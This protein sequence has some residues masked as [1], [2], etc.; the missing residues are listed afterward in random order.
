MNAVV[1][2][3][4]AGTR[5]RP[6][7]D[8]W[9]KP[10]LPI[11]GRPVVVTLLHDLA[12]AGIERITV[13]TGHLAEQVEELLDGLPSGI[14]FVR[15]PEPLCAADTVFRSGDVARFA[16]A[17]AAS[18]AAGAIAVRR[19]QGRPD[20]TRISVESG[21]VVRVVDPGTSSGL[22]AAPLLAAAEPVAARL[23][24]PLPGRAPFELAHVFQQAIDAGEAIASVEIGQTRDL[25]AAQDLVRENF[26]YLR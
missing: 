13:V 25:T 20:H 6:L 17:F 1:M 7:T 23:R 3:A 26:L 10:I 19:Q 18:G 8:R 4:G 12:A 21:R 5:L 9:P 15:Q 24:G 22:T 16:A 2:A 14:R 11:D